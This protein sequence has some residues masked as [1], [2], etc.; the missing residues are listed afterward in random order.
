MVFIALLIS[1]LTTYFWRLASHF[2]I[3]ISRS[4]A[5]SS[6]PGDITFVDRVLYQLFF[7]ASLFVILYISLFLL[8]FIFKNEIKELSLKSKFLLVIPFV[9]TTYISVDLYI[10]LFVN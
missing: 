5:A 9:F 3:D 1:I 6:Y 4:M 7:P 8:T 10:F 2:Y